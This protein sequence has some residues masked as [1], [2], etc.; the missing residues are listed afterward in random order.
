MGSVNQACI[1]KIKINTDKSIKADITCKAC[2]PSRENKE[3]VWNKLV[4]MPKSDSLHN[5]RA[6]MMGFA[7]VNQFDL[8]ED[9]LTEK[10]FDAVSLIGKNDYFYIDYFLMFCAPTMCV[11][12]KNIEKFEKVI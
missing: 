9:F 2:L 5:K 1:W 3:E 8:V 10:F 11:D 6:L 4:N 7:P 12:Q